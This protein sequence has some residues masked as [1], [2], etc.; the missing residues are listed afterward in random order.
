MRRRARQLHHHRKVVLMSGLLH[1]GPVQQPVQHAAPT[2]PH[3]SEGPIFSNTT[4]ASISVPTTTSA[5]PPPTLF[6][7]VQ[8][9]IPTS[10]PRPVDQDGDIE[11]DMGDEHPESSSCRSPRIVKPAPKPLSLRR[12]DLRKH[13][14]LPR[15]GHFGN[16][17]SQADADI[18]GSITAVDIVVG[19]RAVGT[20]R[21]KIKRRD[22]AM[23]RFVGTSER[24]LVAP[25]KIAKLD[26][27]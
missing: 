10:Y 5:P 26:P 18:L 25:K 3:S 13:A 8:P 19:W 14:K 22:V 15:S 1:Q 16:R 27:D 6:N 20:R 4:S 21:T 23:E 24:G 12:R 9:T 11:I 17:V 7:L 2:P